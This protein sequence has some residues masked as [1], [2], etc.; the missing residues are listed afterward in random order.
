[1]RGWMIMR[2]PL[3]S[4]NTACFARRETCSMVLPRSVLMRRA[5][6]TCRSTSVLLSCTRAMRHPSKRGAIS[7]TMVSTSGSS[8][9]LD[10]PPGDVAP[11][12]LALEGDALGAG[13]AGP[14]RQGN[15]RAEA[16]DVQDATTRGAQRAFLVPG[17]A[18]VKDDHVI[19][20]LRLRKTDDAALFRTLRIP[21]RGEHGGDG[22]TL[23]AEHLQAG[24]WAPAPLRD[25][26]EMLRESRGERGKQDLCFGIAETG[27][28]LKHR[29]RAVFQNHQAGVEHALVR[30]PLRRHLSQHRL[31]DFRAHAREQGLR[32]EADGAVGSHAAGIRPRVALAESFVILSGGENE[33]SLA[34]GEREDR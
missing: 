17:C 6:E 1:M 10:F 18:G 13:A 33:D 29:R 8:G 26:R 14:R 11:P 24:R 5:F 16:G 32:G 25:C 3:D 22:G 15:G 4:R 34:V 31:E 2:W 9:T 30:R 23:R 20:E 12:G 27:V 28:E 21:T 7:R 19:S